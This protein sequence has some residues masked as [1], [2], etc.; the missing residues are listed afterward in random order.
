VVRGTIPDNS[1]VIGNPG[2]VAGRTSLFLEM[3][4]ASPNTLDSFHLSE[5]ERESMIRRHFGLPE[6]RLG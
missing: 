4:D 2:R 6:T 3:M 5:P 1:V